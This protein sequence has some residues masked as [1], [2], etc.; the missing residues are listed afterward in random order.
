MPEH[1]TVTLV[2]GAYEA[3]SRGDVPGLLA[4]FTGDAV[5][6]VSADG[7]LGGDHQGPEAISQMLA[8]LF[9]WTGGTVTL[10]V[11]EIFADDSHAIV[12]VRERAKRARDDLPLDVREVHLLRMVD[13]KAAEFWDIPADA[14]RE[15]HDLFFAD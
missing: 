12:S 2:R 1:P 3:L 5:L 8:G 9:E 13:G 10:D 6:H 14:D 11:E 4:A 15:A 7:P